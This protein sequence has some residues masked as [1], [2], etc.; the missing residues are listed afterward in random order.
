MTSEAAIAS[1]R[2]SVAT[3]NLGR[4]PG[5]LN[6]NATA[7]KLQAQSLKRFF[8]RM[9]EL[10][11]A[12]AA[13]EATS[14]DLAV[15]SLLCVQVRIEHVVVTQQRE[16]RR[17]PSLPRLTTSRLPATSR[18]QELCYVDEKRLVAGVFNQS[19]D[20]VRNAGC[21][22]IY[23]TGRWELDQAGVIQPT[24]LTSILND[25]HVRV[26]DAVVLADLKVVGDLLEKPIEST[27][28]HMFDARP[29]AL[30]RRHAAV[31]LKDKE[32]DGR[33]LV[34][35]SY[36][37]QQQDGPRKMTPLQKLELSSTLIQAAD[38][39]GRHLGCDVLIGGDWNVDLS[40]HA[41]ALGPDAL[42]F[43]V[44][45]KYPTA[46]PP[47]NWSGVPKV[48]RSASADNLQLRNQTGA[49]HSAP[50]PQF[51]IDTVLAGFS[52]ARARVHM[53]EG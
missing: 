27:H 23:Q 43:G 1:G 40:R 6:E 39:V 12:P 28:A 8:R 37:G 19:W 9:K 29:L 33:R 47:Y 50:I 3:I 4:G 2:T 31:L 42:E 13:E 10:S 7:I 22:V 41:H 38:I 17:L 46:A 51:S 49:M 25:H 36:H 34:V 35:V 44:N 5:V 48:C 14:K 20:V 26:P 15:P 16:R 24:T 32:N 53:G 21:W 18:P 45:S 30:S 11:R 52:C